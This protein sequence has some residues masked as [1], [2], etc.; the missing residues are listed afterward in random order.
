MW[1]WSVLPKKTRR[2]KIE[3]EVDFSLSVS[4]AE[5]NKKLVMRNTTIISQKEYYDVRIEY[6]QIF[7]ESA[8]TNINYLILDEVWNVFTSNRILDQKLNEKSGN[9]TKK[10]IPDDD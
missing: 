3:V 5:L 1:G 10:I 8:I 9:N 2:N 6:G 7:K 4:V